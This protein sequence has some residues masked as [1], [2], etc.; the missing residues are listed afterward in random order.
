MLSKAPGMTSRLSMIPESAAH[1]ASAHVST[2]G[3]RLRLRNGNT[4]PTLSTA[5]PLFAPEASRIPGRFVIT[6]TDIDRLAAFLRGLDW[7]VVYGLNL[8]DNGPDRAA[9][10]AAYVARALGPQLL[11]FQIGNE[12]DGFGRWSAVRPAGYGIREFL[13]E[14]QKFHA[15][16]HARVPDA[17][18]AGPDVAAE[19]GWVA[20]F[21][22]LKPEN[23]VLLTRHSNAART[24][25]P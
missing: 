18:F 21:A 6:P 19:T 25:T 24:A 10:E 13:A 9:D 4:A 20:P 5:M 7:R 15:A 22:E 23:L 16:I 2:A 8:A 14:W 11:A 17:S 3:M 1:P 12:P